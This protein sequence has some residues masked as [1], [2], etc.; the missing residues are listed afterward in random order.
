M[1][2]GLDFAV[3]VTKKILPTFPSTPSN[4]TSLLRDVRP[5]CPERPGIRDGL[6]TLTKP[7][8]R[9]GSELCQGCLRIPLNFLQAPHVRFV[10]KCRTVAKFGVRDGDS[11]NFRRDFCTLLIFWWDISL[12][13]SRM[14]FPSKRCPKGFHQVPAYAGSSPC[15]Y[16]FKHCEPFAMQGAFRFI[17]PAQVV[18]TS[19][20]RLA[21]KEGPG[22]G[23]G[24]L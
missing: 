5:P 14:G 23:V 6:G 12:F 16:V 9:S 2:L 18:F 11:P 1:K 3:R 19:S 22:G 15:M 4:M 10:Q 13:F 17:S 8:K 24:L 7:L 21:P 20:Q